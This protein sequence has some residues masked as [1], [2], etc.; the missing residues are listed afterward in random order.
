[1]N[2][3]IHTKTCTS[4]FTAA[5]F[6]MAPNGKQPTYPTTGEG[7]NQLRYIHTTNYTTW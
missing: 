6:A 5:L 7:K 3:Y 2:A 4:M 1:M